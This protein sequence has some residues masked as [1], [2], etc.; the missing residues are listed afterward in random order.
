MSL[1]ASSI[2]EERILL[3]SKVGDAVFGFYIFASILFA[4]ILTVAPLEGLAVVWAGTGL[5]FLIGVAGL[6]WREQRYILGMALSLVLYPL[7]IMAT[8]HNGLYFLSIVPVLSVTPILLLS[9]KLGLILSS[10]F[11]LLFSVPVISGAS[12]DEN[13]FIRL[14]ICSLILIAGIHMFVRFTKQRLEESRQ[15][16]IELEAANAALE[17]GRQELV[18][19]NEE[20]IAQ[21]EL[22]D[23]QAQRQA[24]MYAVIAHELRTPA[25]ILKMILDSKDQEKDGVDYSLI[26]GLSDQLLEVLDSLRSVARPEEMLLTATRPVHL[27]EI[28]QN[29]VEL[30]GVIACDQGVGL[31]SDFSG[32][33]DGCILTQSQLIQQSLRNLIN[34]AILHSGGDQVLISASERDA[35]PDL[36]TITIVV[37]DN[38]HGIAPEKAERL[39][40][41]FERGDTRADGTGLG[42]SITREISKKLSGD[43]RYEPN[44]KGGSRFILEF[45]AKA[46]ISGK[47]S[48]LHKEKTGGDHLKGKSVLVVDDNLTIRVLAQSMLE[49]I[50]AKVDVAT[51]GR[52]A[53]LA[54]C[55]QDFDLIMTD[56]FMPEM[57]GIELVKELR[58]QGRTAKII[59]MSASS[60]SDEL[61]RIMEAGA[62][63]VVNKPFD[64]HELNAALIKA[65]DGEKLDLGPSAATG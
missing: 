60:V 61:D 11:L 15:Q 64:V 32:L 1:T 19:A 30:M 17:V 25:A 6:V 55:Y 12:Y 35:E 23:D 2:A 65:F 34:N 5:F 49:K 39:F 22:L 36:K 47:V 37:E 44:P 48:S 13:L 18:L 45:S 21:Q 62:D 58:A 46:A 40:N 56:V 4:V 3:N 63:G 59:G 9:N 52:E 27:T 29:Q 26:G 16:Q 50:G 57:D 54:V 51:N 20:L 10:G 41:A 7:S 33:G 28:L 43:L 14:F 24:Q 42:L 8:W 53:L 31:T 38:G